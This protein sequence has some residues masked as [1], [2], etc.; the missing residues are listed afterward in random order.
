VLKYQKI[1]EITRA[2]LDQINKKVHLEMLARKL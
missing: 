1:P 2:V